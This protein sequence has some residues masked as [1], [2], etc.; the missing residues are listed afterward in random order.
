MKRTGRSARA[1][2]YLHLYGTQ[3]WRKRSLAF[4]AENPWCSRC[5]GVATVTDHVRPHRGNAELFWDWNNLAPLCASC[6]SRDKQAEETRGYALGVDASGMP[7]D[8]NHPWNR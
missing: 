1:S 3:A 5:K 8:P 7:V 4:L 6:H 2:A